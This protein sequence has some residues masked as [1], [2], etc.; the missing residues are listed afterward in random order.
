MFLDIYYNISAGSVR[1]KLS[2][3]QA[4][5]D[6]NI[7]HIIMA[8]MTDRTYQNIIQG[9]DIAFPT[10]SNQNN[11]NH[12]MYLDMVMKIKAPYKPC[13]ENVR[14][15]ATAF[16]FFIETETTVGKIQLEFTLIAP[17]TLF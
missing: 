16:L 2:F 14:S 4:L 5:K 9:R 6:R 17:T 3:K 1:D 10:W 13:F 12:N 7:S 8:Q 11:I 15:Y